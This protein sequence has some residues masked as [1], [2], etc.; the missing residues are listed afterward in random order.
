MTEKLLGSAYFLYHSIGM[1]PGH[2]ERLAAEL[3][4]FSAIWTRPDDG[5][6]PSVLT[7]RQEFIERWS[8]LIDA[9]AGSLTSTE[10]VTT[11]LFSLVGSLPSKRLKGKRVLV[12]ADCF[13]SLHFLLSGIS[14]RMGFTLDTVPLRQGERFV[15]DEDILAH[16]QEDVA[17]T[18]L[19]WVS[20]TTSHRCDVTA[21]AEHGRRMG[22][23]VV[24]DATQ[25]VGIIPLTVENTCI[26]ALISSSLKWIG[27]TAGAGILYVRPELLNECQPEFRGWFSQENPFS[28]DLAAFHYAGDARRFDH[29]TPSPLAAIATLPAL[30]WLEET[31]IPG[32]RAHNL[33]LSEM[34]ISKALEKGW[35]IISPL[36][37]EK[38]GGSIM[39]ELPEHVDGAALVAQLRASHIYCDVRGRTLRLSPGAVTTQDGVEDL[40]NHLAPALAN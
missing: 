32:L 27:G 4:R 26:D 35:T 3:A 12:S 8:R 29:G 6:W 30:R 11:A 7:S 39:L 40:C 23:V 17:L 21:L 33:K 14:E 25:G 19:T 37:A 9:P 31:G 36:D 10:N 2:E 13:P 16:W 15:R 34:L 20:S 22:S 5:Q 18:L 28:W 24:V 1:I 38:R